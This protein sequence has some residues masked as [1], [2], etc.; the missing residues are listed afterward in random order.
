MKATW[1]A[2]LLL[3]AVTVTCLAEPP[4]KPTA[5]NRPPKSAVPAGVEVI[6]D[7][8]IGTGGGRT[9]H[10]EIAR[11]KEP[12]A[13]KMLTLRAGWNQIMVRGYCIGYP[14]FRVGLVLDAPAEKLWTLTLS[15]TPH[16]Q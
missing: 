9:L 6:H 3:L 5:P 16:V 8:E 13:T 2:F 4:S 10:A 7:V 14:P 15:A 1:I 11:P 12:V